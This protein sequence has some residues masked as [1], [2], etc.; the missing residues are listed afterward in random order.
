MPKLTIDGK[1]VVVE[2]GATVIQA[3]EQIGIEIPRFCYHPR[4]A[5]AGNCRM[6]LVEIEKAP[7]PVASCAQ[8]AM[9]NM[10]VHTNTPLVKKAREGVMEF[11]LINHPLDCPICD[12]A[13]ECDLQD[14]SM[15]YGKGESRYEEEKRSVLDKDFGPLIKTQMTR[16]IHCTRCVRF[17]TDVAGIPEIG[18]LYRGEDTEIATYVEKAVDSELSGN[19]I[20]LCPVGALTSKP[21]AFKARS[22]ELEK[23]ESIDVL[24]AVGSNIRIDSRGKQVMRILPRIN[25]DINEEWISDKTRFAYDGL[26]K[27]RLDKP[28]IKKNGKLVQATWEEAFKA[29][30]S[31]LKKLKPEEISAIAGDLVD[32]ESMLVLKDLW[33]ELGSDNLD[34]RQHCEKLDISQRANYLFN[35]S[36]TSI[37]DADFCLIIG[38]NP[39]KEAAILNAR[40]K[41][42][43]LAGNIEIAVLGSEVDLTYKYNYLGNELAILKSIADGSHPIVTK[44]KHYKT[45]MLILGSQVISLDDGAEI[46]N[47]CKDIAQKYNFISDEWNGFNILNRSAAIVGGLDIGFVPQKP[48]SNVKEFLDAAQDSKIKLI[49]LLGADEVDTTKLKNTFVIYQGH[50]GDRGAHAADVILPGCAYTEKSSTYVNLEGRVQ[51]AYRAVFAPGESKLDWQIIIE[52]AEC[53]DIDLGYKS[54]AEIRKKMIEVAPHFAKIGLIDKAQWKIKDNKY[55]CVSKVI[56][57]NDSNYY[58]TDSICRA[59]VTMSKCADLFGEKNNQCK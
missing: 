4:L 12:Q 42:A 22:W 54:L 52:L 25:E 2:E 17:I 40:I 30:S 56:G 44:L 32:V 55:N 45:P 21:Y 47:L 19:I 36:I 34:C 39:K 6:C 15:A 7:K 38:S 31:E 33:Q 24:D 35:T 29:I 14:Q 49:Y 9:E 58:L 48:D 23:T 53:M 57:Y 3:C 28:Y 11:L 43:H 5:I 41:K 59:S 26:S 51:R 27:Q 37:E 16:C 46:I 20:D 13:G 50:H 18:S 8:P 10:V 1:E